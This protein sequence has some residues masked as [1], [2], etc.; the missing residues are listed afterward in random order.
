MNDFK[1][2]AIRPLKKCN[3]KFTKI[4]KED[5]SYVFFNDFDFSEYTEKSKKI[6]KKESKIND[7]YHHKTK[8]K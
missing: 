7:F 4:L 1:L 5:T 6:K 3:I 8:I 2:I